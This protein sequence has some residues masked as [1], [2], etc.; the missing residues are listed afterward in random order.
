VNAAAPTA[1]LVATDFGEVSRKAVDW[2]VDLANALHAALHI[3]NVCD[4][5]MAALPDTAF[6]AS[7]TA[8]SRMLDAAQAAMDAEM[9][10]VRRR[11]RVPVDGLVKQGDPRDG[12]PHLASSC[13]AQLIVVGSHGR[14]GFARAL[15]G[16]VAESI[17]RA[18]EVPV[19]VVHNDGKPAEE[20]L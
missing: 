16:S 19:I 5:P 1:I 17:V 3:A 7:A 20:W 13:G 18:S 6:V 15:L 10:R 11:A 12:V 8:G 4:I 2:A 9:A 14:R